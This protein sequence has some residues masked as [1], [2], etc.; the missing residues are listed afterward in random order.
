MIAILATALVPILR[1]M[2]PSSSCL[3]DGTPRSLAQEIA[4][5][6]ARLDPLARTPELRAEVA[7]LRE[8]ARR[9]AERAAEL[10]RCRAGTS[11]S[12]SGSSRKRG[13]ASSICTSWMRRS[14]KPAS[15]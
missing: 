12:A 5:A 14:A 4:A 15:Q 7:R 1:R 8:L 11:I 10:R 13:L 6:A 3:G 9:R 2:T